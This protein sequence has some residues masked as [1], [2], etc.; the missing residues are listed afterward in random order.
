MSFRTEM[1][2]SLTW[3]PL[4]CT[5]ALSGCYLYRD[6]ITPAPVIAATTLPRSAAVEDLDSLVTIVSEVHPNPSPQLRALRDSLAHAWPETVSRAR[7][8]RDMNRLLAVLGDGHTGLSLDRL[9]EEAALANGGRSWPFAVRRTMDGIIIGRVVGSDTTVLRSGDR[10]ESI[11]GMPIDSLVEAIGRAVPAELPEYR[12][13]VVLRFLGSSLWMEGIRPPADVRVTG[14]DGASRADHA[15][16]ATR[17]EL[18]AASSQQG[19]PEPLTVL[20]V[21]DSVLLL[22]FRRMWGS[23]ERAAFTARLDSAFEAAAQT[24]V[25]AVVVDLRRNGGGDS[26]WGTQLLSYVTGDSLS[27]GVR[28]E[29]K[30]SRRY[31]MFFKAR[32]SPLLRY[33]IPFS[34]FDAPIG[35]LFSGP[36][37]TMAVIPFTPSLPAANPRRFERPLCLL[38]GPGTFSSAMMLA[39]TARRSGVAILIG[40]PTGEPPNSGGEVM[41][42]HLRR[43]GLNGQ[44]S[45][46]Y[47]MLDEDPA[48][49]RRGVLP[50]IT[51]VPTREDI[52][53][54]RDPVMER[55]MECG[56]T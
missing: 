18:Q 2:T 46:A 36:D 21:R 39:N 3:I 42:F 43:S 25:R 34:W 19:Q 40:E 1:R 48:G 49:D 9:E 16:G 44:V 38:I 51:V 56:R 20:G 24:G 5:V 15:A 29:W 31:R 17:Q 55:A 35:G 32:V 4:A 27:Q 8:A 53:A 26:R 50:H 47:F 37:G 22:D 52:R 6:P 45:S 10:L 11:N 33:T 28:K 14:V 13:A 12:D 41:S 23:P 54:G 7:L 30:G